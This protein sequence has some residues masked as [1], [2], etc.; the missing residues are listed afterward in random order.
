MKYCV[1]LLKGWGAA[2]ISILTAHL[3]DF[4]TLNEAVKYYICLNIMLDFIVAAAGFVA[5]ILI[6]KT[7]WR[8][9]HTVTGLLI[10]QTMGV[11]D[12]YWVQSYDDMV[13]P[14]WLDMLWA[15]IETITVYYIAGSYY[16]AVK[17]SVYDPPNL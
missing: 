5:M 17:L 3:S 1:L 13:L 12:I 2:V 15:F 4:L 8:V 7:P 14:S 6:S 9:V 16:I 11:L 10:A